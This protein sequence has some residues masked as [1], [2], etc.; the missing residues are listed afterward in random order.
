MS[1]FTYCPDCKARSDQAHYRGCNGGWRTLDTLPRDTPV[2]VAC[3]DGQVR[4]WTG[5]Y[6]NRIRIPAVAWMPLPAPPKAEPK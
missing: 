4:I 6:P 2:L 1:D 5:S 3:A